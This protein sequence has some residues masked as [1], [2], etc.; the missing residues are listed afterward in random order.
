MIKKLFSA[1]SLATIFL[2][3]TSCEK[4]D[5]FYDIEDVSKLKMLSFEYW[6]LYDFTVAPDVDAENV[7]HESLFASLPSC[8]LDN[9]F[10]FTLDGEMI[11]HEGYTKCAVNDPDSFI[12]YF[13]LSEKESKIVMWA[14]P[15]NPEG[16]H[17]FSGN[18]FYPSVD[19]FYWVFRKYNELSE[20]TEEHSYYFRQKD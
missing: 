11:T 10:E 2:V 17:L 7:N 16:T 1:I 3:F 18:I 6:E 4:E 9:V 20:K 19:E 8:E 5:S 15:E 13:T 14:D 12:T